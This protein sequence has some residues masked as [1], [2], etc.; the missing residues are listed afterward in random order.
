MSHID[1]VSVGSDVPANAFPFS[2]FPSP[3]SAS[4]RFDPTHVLLPQELCGAV[5]KTPLD[6][7]CNSS[8][9]LP[10]SSSVY[11]NVTARWCKVSCKPPGNEAS[12]ELV[13]LSSSPPTPPWPTAEPHPDGSVSDEQPRQGREDMYASK[14]TMKNVPLCHTKPSSHSKDP[15]PALSTE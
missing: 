6:L 14:Q 1:K 8:G 9:T 12:L 11:Y 2:L 5:E 3:F 7:T 10:S 4:A 13:L 15:I